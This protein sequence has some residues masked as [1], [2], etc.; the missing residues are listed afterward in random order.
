M[1]KNLFVNFILL[2]YYFHS[3]ARTHST[4]EI[5]TFLNS[6]FYDLRSKFYFLNN[7]FYDFCSKLTDTMIFNFK[8]QKFLLQV[9]KLTTKILK[10][11]N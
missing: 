4:W 7:N 8:S 6:N 3:S 10:I 11:I 2:I 1:K 5:F 9:L